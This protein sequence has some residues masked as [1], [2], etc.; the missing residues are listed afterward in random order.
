MARPKLIQG[1]QFLK[2]MVFNYDFI[3][4]LQDLM[5]LPQVKQKMKHQETPVEIPR[6]APGAGGVGAAPVLS[7]PRSPGAGWGAD[8][9]PCRTDPPVPSP[10]ARVDPPPL[11][12]PLPPSLCALPCRA[13]PQ[14]INPSPPGEMR[15]DEFSGTSYL[16]NRVPPLLFRS[17]CPPAPFI[18]LLREGRGVGGRGS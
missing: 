18:H 9:D 2:K 12:P 11:P 13:A 5:S 15:G 17:Q 7:P 10:R 16:R 6:E 3:F 14:L 8:P 4:P 1:F